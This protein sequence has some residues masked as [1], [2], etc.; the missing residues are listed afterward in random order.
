MSA[1]PKTLI[2][3]DNAMQTLETIRCQRF[4]IDESVVEVSVLVRL[5]SDRPGLAY[6]VLGK[7]VS[8]SVVSLHSFLVAVGS[9]YISEEGILKK[10]NQ[11]RL[12]ALPE[13]APRVQSVL[14]LAGVPAAFHKCLCS[15]RGTDSAEDITMFL[16]GMVHGS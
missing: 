14:S 3:F 15:L 7:N 11:R 5:G 8:V 1:E 9:E 10:K 4:A 13:T 2:H 16:R 6:T 12:W